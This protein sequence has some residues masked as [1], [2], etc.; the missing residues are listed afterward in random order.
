VVHAC[1]AY[2]KTLNRS[3][4]RKLKATTPHSHTNLRYLSSSDMEARINE[5]Q[6]KQRLLARKVSYLSK[7]LTEVTIEYGVYLHG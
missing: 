5:L 2:R 7:K 6:H 1:I 4:G 3:V